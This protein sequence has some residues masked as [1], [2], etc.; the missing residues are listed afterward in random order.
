MAYVVRF[1]SF[2]MNTCSCGSMESKRAKIGEIHD[3]ISVQIESI[4]IEQNL[5]VVHGNEIVIRRKI[6]LCVGHESDRRRVSDRRGD[7]RV[8]ECHSSVEIQ[9]VIDFIVGK[10]ARLATVEH[11][12]VEFEQKPDEALESIGGALYEV[13]CFP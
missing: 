12:P 9:S 8:I 7:D 13:V 6:D 3:G 10:Q 4:G 2:E 5:V 1:H 11:R